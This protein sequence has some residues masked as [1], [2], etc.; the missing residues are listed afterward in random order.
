M[1]G[2]LKDCA[3]RCTKRPLPSLLSIVPGEPFSPAPGSAKIWWRSRRIPKS[4]SCSLPQM[5]STSGDPTPKSAPTRGRL[6]ATNGKTLDAS[7]LE[8]WLWEGACIARGPLDAPKFKDYILPLIFLKR[9]S[10]VFAGEVA[11]LGQEFGDPKTAARLVEGDH[12]LVRF[13]IPEGAR[14]PAIAQKTTGLG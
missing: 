14:W 8:S 4:A 6:M 3:E 1:G 12:K 9:L 11:H 7:T 13:Y 5:I 2:T 10:D